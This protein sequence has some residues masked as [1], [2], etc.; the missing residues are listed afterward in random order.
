MNL[1]WV[2][3]VDWRSLV[4]NRLEER[5]LD[6]KGAAFIWWSFR[7]HGRDLLLNFW[8]IF[9]SIH[10]LFFAG[11]SPFS[12]FL[13]LLQSL[14]PFNILLISPFISHALLPNHSYP[15]MFMLMLL[16]LLE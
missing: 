7:M 5:V 3:V 13:L 11:A 10:P 1:K 15:L 12:L 9:G 4:G 14:I 16:F 8:I 6:D 2:S